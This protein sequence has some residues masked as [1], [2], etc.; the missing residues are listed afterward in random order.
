MKHRFAISIASLALGAALLA[1]CALLPATRSEQAAGEPTPTPIPTTAIALKP[2]YQVQ[3]GE[4]V[5]TSKFSG[6]ISPVVEEELYF[7]ADGRL[8]AVFFKRNDAVAKGDVIAELEIDGLERELKAAELELER[9]EVTLAEAERKLEYDRRVAQKQLEIAQI[10]LDG[11]DS[12]RDS[13]HAE[14]DAQ[15]KEVELAQI[16]VERLEAGVSPLLQN[17]V[18]RARYAVQKLNEQI[19]EAQIIAPFDGVLLSLTLSPGQAI[20]AYAPVAS[21]ADPSTLEVSSN[22][23]SDQLQLL[24][25][26][27]PVTME[28]ASRP[29][30]KL[31]GFIR[32]LPYPYGSGGSGQTL[33]EKDKSTRVTIEAAT[34]VLASL[35]LGELVNVTAIIES[36]DNVVWVPPQ[37]IRNFNGRRFAVV[38]DGD[39]QRRVDIKLGIQAEERVEIM[40]GL[41]EGQTVVGP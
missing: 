25:E 21:L 27:M 35:L 33:E 10:R 31:D 28:L 17:D 29:G 3:V 6:R 4:V 40:E 32:R 22:L 8:R 30:Q 26:K 2:T 39:V 19:A 36:K 37:A 11:V 20:T 23:L 15:R 34:D 7:R 5:K 14:V 16:E 41:Q 38:Q 24:A 18:T 12:N 13:T 1:G 9:A